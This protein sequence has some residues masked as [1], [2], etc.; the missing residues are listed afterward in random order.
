MA[1][2]RR[3]I[4]RAAP[5]VPI[6]PVPGRKGMRDPEDCHQEEEGGHDLKHKGRGEV[7]PSEVAGAPAVLAEPAAPPLRLA[8][9]N[10]L[11]E[12]IM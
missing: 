10:A 5:P 9:E 8:R 3:R 11:P 1:G 6:S 12:R 2:P 7:V 4:D